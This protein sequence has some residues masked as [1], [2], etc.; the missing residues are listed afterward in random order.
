MSA[1]NHFTKDYLFLTSNLHR[2]HDQK[3]SP[4]TTGRLFMHNIR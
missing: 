3:W 2:E 1:N 4:N